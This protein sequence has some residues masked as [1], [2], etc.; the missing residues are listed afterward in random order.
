MTAEYYGPTV[1]AAQEASRLLALDSNGQEQDW[2]IE[3][4]DP[5][6][7][8][9][10]LDVLEMQQFSQD[11]KAALCLLVLASFESGFN[12]GDVDASRM[13]RATDFLFKDVVVLAQMR[14]Y[15]LGLGLTDHVNLMKKLLSAK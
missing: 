9:G 12:V 1:K 13:R 8:D 15:W 11:V 3:L 4:A 2:E 6:K 5:N 10:M 14:F 7:I